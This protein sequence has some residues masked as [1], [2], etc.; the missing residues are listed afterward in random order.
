MTRERNI[1]VL[2]YL[3]HDASR[4]TLYWLGPNSAPVL[5]DLPSNRQRTALWILSLLA[6]IPQGQ[7]KSPSSV[8]PWSP[9]TE[10]KMPQAVN[11]LS[12]L[13]RRNAEAG[14]GKVRIERRL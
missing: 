8:F 2:K 1:R 6:H 14:T 9:S 3:C 4:W 5:L 11:C 10:I 13:C 7:F 12:K